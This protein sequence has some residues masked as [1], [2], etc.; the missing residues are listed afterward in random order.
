MSFVAVA[1]GGAGL[2]GA[3]AAIG[4]ALIG[5]KAAGDA[6]DKSVAAQRE[7]LASQERL[8]REGMAYQERQATRSDQLLRDFNAQAQT[9]LK[10]FQDAQLSALGQAQALTDPNNPLYQQQR[11]I[12]TQAIQ[13][14]LAAQGLLRSKNQVDLLSNLELG[15]GQ[16]RANQINALASLGAV[17]QGAQNT[18]GLGAGLASLAGNLGANVGQAFGNLG[19]ANA[20]G[21]SAIGQANAQGIMGQANALAG[22]L[23]GVNNAIQG[24]AGNLLALNNQAG[25]M[26]WLKSLLTR[27]VGSGGSGLSTTLINPAFR[28][29]A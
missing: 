1:V 19:A 21:I 23:T 29:L 20:Q 25:Q 17:Q 16:Q 28:S 5:S 26:E 12:E 8:A 24:T 6:T 4:G 22:G 14:Q 11:Q 10:P 15:L 3:G 13:R 18:M 7:A 27:N 2:L 9:Q